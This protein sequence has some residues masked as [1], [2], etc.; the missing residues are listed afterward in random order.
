M[1]YDDVNVSWALGMHVGRSA[2]TIR[3][4]DVVLYILDVT[5]DLN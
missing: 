2:V 3:S 5:S 4:V 1:N